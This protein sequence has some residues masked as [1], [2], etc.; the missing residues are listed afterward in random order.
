MIKLGILCESIIELIYR[1]DRVTPPR[2]N[3][4]VKRIDTLARENQLPK[5]VVDILHLVRKSRNKAAHQHWG[6]T[7]AVERFLP[8]VHSL[9]WWFEASYGDPNVKVA[10]YV[11]PAKQTGRIQQA[12]ALERQ[13]AA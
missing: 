2:E 6:S 4:A 3:T 11:Q 10:K 8:M 7:A 1:Y 13:T 12:A 9:A 5:E